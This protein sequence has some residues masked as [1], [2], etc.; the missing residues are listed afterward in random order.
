MF[1]IFNGHFLKNKCSWQPTFKWLYRHNGLEL[2]HNNNNIIRENCLHS[3]ISVDSVLWRTSTHIYS[4]NKKPSLSLQFIIAWSVCKSSEFQTAWH[5][6]FELHSC[7]G[8]SLT[9]LAGQSKLNMKDKKQREGGK[10]NWMQ[11]ILGEE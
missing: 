9:S 2:K 3:I 4:L 1:W 8:A 11:W 7:L 10:L 5:E 6:S